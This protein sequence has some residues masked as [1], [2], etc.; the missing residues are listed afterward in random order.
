MISKEVFNFFV[1]VVVVCCCWRLHLELLYIYEMRAVKLHNI[2]NTK[3]KWNEKRNEITETD[4]SFVDKPTT[5]NI[6]LYTK[7]IIK[8]VLL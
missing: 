7:L 6:F 3:W 5:S 8:L 4:Q 2:E 1:V